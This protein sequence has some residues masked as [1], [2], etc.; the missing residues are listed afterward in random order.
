MSGF[1]TSTRAGDM[2]MRLRAQNMRNARDQTKRLE[3]DNRKM[4]DRLRELKTVMTKEKEERERQ[5]GGFWGRGQAQVGSLTKYA[6]EV[7]SSKSDRAPREGK[8][9]K[10]KVLQDEPI[11][12]PKRSAQPGTMKYIAQRKLPPGPGPVPRDKQKGPRCGQ[13]EDRAATLSCVQCSEIYCPGCFAAFHVKGALKQ[14]RSVPINASG[15][16][17]CMSPHPSVDP[18]QSPRASQASGS[19]VNQSASYGEDSGA[20]SARQP[21]ISQV[22][23]APTTG[24]G[25][26]LLEGAYDESQSAASFQA[27]LMAWREGPSSSPSTSSSSSPSKDSDR[28]RTARSNRSRKVVVASPVKSPV[29]AVDE[30]T[31][32]PEESKVP[33]IKFTSSLSYAERLLLKRHRRTELAEVATPRLGNQSP[34]RNGAGD[35]SQHMASQDF[36]SLTGTRSNR[37]TSASRSSGSFSRR[38][39]PTSSARKGQTYREDT[40]V[41]DG[42]RVNF[43]SLFEAVTS[44]E[45][46]DQL[47]ARRSH[48]ST[49]TVSITEIKSTYPTEPP[50]FKSSVTYVVEE[51]KPMEAWNI[52]QSQISS[53]TFVKDKSGHFSSTSS[54]VQPPRIRGS[55]TDLFPVEESTNGSS[56]NTSQRSSFSTDGRL[57]S[58]QEKQQQQQHFGVNEPRDHIHHGQDIPDEVSSPVSPSKNQSLQ[59]KMKPESETGSTDSSEVVNGKA[60]KMQR[61]P[62]ASSRPKSSAQSSRPGSRAHSRAASRIKIEGTLTKSPSTALKQVAQMVQSPEHTYTYQSPLE[63]FFLAG[64]EGQAPPPPGEDRVLTPSKGRKPSSASRPKSRADG[65]TS[66]REEK[67]KISY[68]LYKMAPKSWRPDSSLGEAVPLSEVKLEEPQEEM[69]MSYSYSGQMSGKATEW[70]PSSSHNNSRFHPDEFGLNSSLVFGDEMFTE[71][72]AAAAAAEGTES[73]ATTPTPGLPSRNRHRLEQHGSMKPSTPHDVRHPHHH[74]VNSDQTFRQLEEANRDDDDVTPTPSRATRR[75]SANRRSFT[76]GNPDSLDSVYNSSANSSITGSTEIQKSVDQNESVGAH[77]ENIARRSANLRRFSG[78]S[79]RTVSSPLPPSNM[80]PTPPP[81]VASHKPELET[82][83]FGRGASSQAARSAQLSRRSVRSSSDLSSDPHSQ[84]AASPSESRRLV[85]TSAKRDHQ[86]NLRQSG[87][88]NF[89]TN[90]STHDNEASSGHRVQMESTSASKQSTKSSAGLR[91]H[92]SDIHT[93]SQPLK[94]KP[95]SEPHNRPAS[96]S[97]RINTVQRNRTPSQQW[98]PVSSRDGAE[99]GSKTGTTLSASMDGTGHLRQ[100]TVIADV[101]Q[102]R[103]QEDGWMDGEDDDDDENGGVLYNY[104]DGNDLDFVRVMSRQSQRRDDQAGKSILRSSQHW[105]TEVRPFSGGRASATSLK[106]GNFSAHSAADG[107]RG[108]NNAASLKNARL[109]SASSRPS[110]CMSQ[111]SGRE[112]RA[113]VMDGE[114]LSVYDAV[115]AV[116]AEDDQDTEDRE[117]LEKLE[118]ELASDTGRLTAD[119]QISRMSMLDN[120]DDIGSGSSSRSSARSLRKSSERD[121]DVSAKLLEDEQH[122]QEEVDELDMRRSVTLDEDEVKALR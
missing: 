11:E 76:P 109:R 101:L 43:Q 91:R 23:A 9:K 22:G 110:S 29:I 61:K 121:Y 92:M 88:L 46:P 90:H 12:V 74:H 95:H 7:L 78:S 75:K 18:H 83:S 39:P 45:S 102:S 119:G 37:P 80:V 63:E 108:S 82:G 89:S 122:A 72:A 106:A 26:S 69:T 116:P 60:S 8:K 55:I 57:K 2:S 86:S 16:R 25:G 28:E 21:P 15:P 94:A 112:S 64:V 4:E 40:F 51:A 85:A 97:S 100:D 84:T 17:V 24:G 44:S 114:D 49:S 5:G 120:E 53:A 67:F 41:D 50:K 66:A 65:G 77:P 30:S 38:E 104:D 87:H 32:T 58:A 54:T 56:N 48:S 113:I 117:T 105:E 111:A 71:D 62:V 52:Q 34:P 70:R 59:S 68:K 98:R 42:E 35:Q 33:E 73:S 47:S 27:A 79:S 36:A 1:N 10:I 93:N 96:M 103:V 13:C 6:D 99:L 107:G 81:P 20:S 19:V 31:G 115:G 118:W 14:H 3:E